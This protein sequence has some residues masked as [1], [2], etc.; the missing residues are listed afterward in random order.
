MANQHTKKAQAAPQVEAPAPAP[1][2][3]P[4]QVRSII[5]VRVYRKDGTIDEFVQA[6]PEIK[7]GEPFTASVTTGE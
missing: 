6:I 4:V 7:H 3:A 1:A 5:R 2:P